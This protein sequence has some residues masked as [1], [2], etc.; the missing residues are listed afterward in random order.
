LFSDYSESGYWIDCE[1][2]AIDQDI[3]IEFVSDF[4]GN[5]A[6]VNNFPDRGAIE[7]QNIGTQT[8]QT[9]P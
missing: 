1:S 7:N 2:P 5:Q 6:T 8:C 9:D 3:P 4:L